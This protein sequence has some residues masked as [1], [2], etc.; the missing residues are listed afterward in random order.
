VPS[1]RGR[2]RAATPAASS[3]RTT[4]GP[5]VLLAAALL[6]GCQPYVQGNGIFLE[7]TCD[8]PPFDAISVTD[9]IQLQV[10]GGA[11]QQVVTVSGD[12][13]VLQHIETSVHQD[14]QRGSVLVVKST[15]AVFDSVNPVKAVVAATALNGLSADEA[16]QVTATS[17]ASPQ[18]SVVASDAAKLTLSGGGGATLD[19]TL[20]AGQHGGA[21]LDARGFPV[22]V[23]TVA[24]QAPAT[25]A[26][27][28]ARVRVSGTAVEGASLSN[29]G[30]ATC[31]VEAPPGVV[32]CST[33]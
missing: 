6:A 13:N 33:P 1:P 15:I 14:P 10:T 22:E 12:E 32:S 24:L 31:D 4:A 9:G 2:R 7:Q 11:A 19:V 25:Q 17:V 21:T 23:A 16:C 29:T 18:F 30:T 26:Q 8:V 5:A 3:R 20:A 28:A 27:L